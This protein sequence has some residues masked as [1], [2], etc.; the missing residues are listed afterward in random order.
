[1]KNK[2][3]APL[4]LSECAR[5]LADDLGDRAPAEITLKRWRKD[6]LLNK[7]LRKPTDGGVRPLFD[8]DQVLAVVSTRSL[9]NRPKPGMNAAARPGRSQASDV[10]L[11]TM[12]EKVVRKVLLETS[13]PSRPSQDAQG[14]GAEEIKRAVD[15]LDAARR[16]LMLKYDS[17]LNMLR[18]RL[19][20]AQAA[21]QKASV[22]PLDAARITSR[23]DEINSKLSSM[24][25]R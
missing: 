20:D 19:N 23:L 9:A 7:A 12:V 3:A 18:G 22:A 10:D 14:A 16:Q 6:G 25:N 15:G 2:R 21:L 24:A 8:Y 13:T 1:M 17:E 5:K 4:T 11:A